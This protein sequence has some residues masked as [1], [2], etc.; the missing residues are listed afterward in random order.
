[1]PRNTD[2]AMLAD[3]SDA[4]IDSSKYTGPTPE[5]LAFNPVNL[6]CYLKDNSYPDADI[7]E[8]T[9]L[10]EE[11]FHNLPPLATQEIL[12]E[13]TIPTMDENGDT[14]THSE[15]DPANIFVTK[16]IRHYT[17]TG[18]TPPLGLEH[19]PEPSTDSPARRSRD[20]PR[21]AGA[22]ET[23]DD[24]IRPPDTVITTPFLSEVAMAGYR[25]GRS[26]RAFAAS[27]KNRLTQSSVENPSETADSVTNAE[28]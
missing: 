12:L 14:V 2:L 19:A 22:I 9:N 25:T 16:Y 11:Q 15:R 21:S 18:D 24:E 6:Y 23:S 13:W 28:D 7:A 26:I 17:V 5:S 10:F 3:A 27:A 20:P 4:E 8:L 1:M